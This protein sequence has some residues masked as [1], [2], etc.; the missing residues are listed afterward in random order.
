[1]ANE[2]TYSSIGD[3]TTS[4]VLSTEYLQLRSSTEALPNH[5][6]LYYA[7]SIVG[8]G[9]NTIKVPHIGLMGG[10]DA[11]ASTSDGSAASNTAVT[12]A[13]STIAV[14]RQSLRRE[15]TD[16]A[17]MV[18]PDLINPGIFAQDALDAY[19]ARLTDMICDVIDGFT[20]TVGSSG[21]DLSL[22]NI[23]AG[24]GTAKGLYAAGPW[25]G[26]LHT[27]Q[28]TDFINDAGLTSG[29]VLQWQPAT[30]EMIVLRTSAFQGT[31]LGV[32]WF[33]SKRVVTADSGAN[34]AGAI[35]AR[36]AVLFADG[37][38]SVRDPN[39]QI[40]LGGQVLVERERTSASGLDAF[41][42]HAYLGA[43]KG[44]EFGVSVITDA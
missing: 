25:M 18:R 9:S 11:L 32:D 41:T 5:P 21:V 4:E 23:L 2:I 24:I 28:W 30:A 34:R 15:H 37:V 22:A 17:A 43:A 29:G 36:G 8:R 26:V 12:D 31:F 7:G 27:Q 3:L 39:N 14:T 44:V 33:V 20:A 10:Y 42:S 1:M 40:V 35:F 38:P 13:S 6:A 16:L 19:S